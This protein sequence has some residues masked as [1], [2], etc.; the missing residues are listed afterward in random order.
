MT[1]DDDTAAHS[2]ETAI[3]AG[4]AVFNVG[5]YHAAHDAWEDYWLALESGTADERFLHGLIQ[6]TAAAHHAANDRR[7][8]AVGLA[9]SALTYLGGVGATY[10]GVD[11]E[12]VVRYLEA[13]Q[14]ASDVAA[15]AVPP[16]LI[17]DASIA[18]ED[19]DADAASIAEKL[20]AGD[21]H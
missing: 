1:E 18:V 7:E 17:D 11:L 20:L 19:L 3:A 6:F 15:V 5:H 9:A 16:L 21:E 10:R 8:G 2:L 12:P 4:A 13:L 14:A